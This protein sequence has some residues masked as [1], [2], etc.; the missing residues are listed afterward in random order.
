MIPIEELTVE[1]RDVLSPDRRSMEDKAAAFDLLIALV[2][3]T[4]EE[5]V[6]VPPS[7]GGPAVRVRCHC[8]PQGDWLTAIAVAAHAHAVPSTPPRAARCEKCDS[9]LHL[10]FGRLRCRNCP[11]DARSTMPTLDEIPPT[12][13]NSGQ[14]SSEGREP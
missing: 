3:R 14:G 2:T 1:R 4:N 5:V 8:Q 7:R 11:P 6:L 9:V 12:M 10:E 13:R